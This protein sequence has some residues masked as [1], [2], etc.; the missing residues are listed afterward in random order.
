M[1][2]KLRKKNY[3]DSNVQGSLLK[4]IFSHWVTFFFVCGCSVILLQTML[5]DPNVDFVKRFQDQLQEFSFFAIVMLALLPAFMLDT[6]RFSNRFVGPIVRLR[7]HLRQLRDGDTS[8]CAFRGNDFWSE[9]ADEFNQVAD[10][11]KKQQEE[12]RELKG[13][14]AKDTNIEEEVASLN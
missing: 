14:P 3:I 1:S 12:I 7:R 4:R 9:M 8:E 11:V 13:L 2:K 5:G 10:L 6:I